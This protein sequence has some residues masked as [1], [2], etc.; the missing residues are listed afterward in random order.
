[1]LS[2]GKLVLPGA[3]A[4]GAV[5]L[6]VS[7]WRDLRS[8]RLIAAV[9]REQLAV[10]QP[11]VGPGAMRVA[12]LPAEASPPAD[13][14]RQPRSAAT[15]ENA[16][17]GFRG[18]GGT[19]DESAM[20][21][22]PEYR[23]ARLVQLGMTM[24]RFH[25]GAAMELGLSAAEADALFALLA[26]QQLDAQSVQ[27][28]EPAL[29][30]AAMLQQQLKQMEALHQRQQAAIEL[31][32]GGKYHQWQDY[33]ASRPV[34]AR[35]DQLRASLASNG[36]PL[37]DA[38]ARALVTAL[39]PEQKRMEQAM[40]EMA[41]SGAA[42]AGIEEMFRIEA[43]GEQRMLDVARAHLDERQLQTFRAMIDSQQAMMRA[44]S[45]AQAAQAP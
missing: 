43:D 5:M 41:R 29:H 27:M 13:V 15:P 22:D 39:V 16:A 6:S 42:P 34:R 40:M 10:R 2:P 44:Q 35:V 26:E 23:K 1:M 31:Q 17:G 28:A 24:R 45:R 11:A 30:D 33:E 14:G 38:Q 19:S 18:F 9:L 36:F 20:L 4:I 8:E 12:E 25:A 7:L 32:L 37:G 21:R 3:L